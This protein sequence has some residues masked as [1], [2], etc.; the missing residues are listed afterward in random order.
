MVRVEREWRKVPR[1]AV[2]GG[3]LSVT[4]E[5]GYIPA[6]SAEFESERSDEAAAKKRPELTI[7]CIAARGRARLRRRRRDRLTPLRAPMIGMTCSSLS[8]GWPAH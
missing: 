3:F 7:P 1:I 4:E 8:W 5:G 2:D 6:E